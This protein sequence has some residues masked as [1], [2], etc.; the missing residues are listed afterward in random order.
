MAW[1]DTG[2][3]EWAPLPRVHISELPFERF[4]CEF[5]LPRM[6]C[7][8]GA[9]LL[10]LP[11]APSLAPRA[12]RLC[13]FTHSSAAHHPSLLI[14]ANNRAEG[15]GDTFEA[16]ER[17]QSLDYFISHDAIGEAKHGKMSLTTIKTPFDLSTEKVQTVGS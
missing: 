4:L 5:A 14:S 9:S 17:W 8:I 3:L 6:P 10:T 12:C 1:G 13:A 16:R 11:T 2:G 15:A 7:I